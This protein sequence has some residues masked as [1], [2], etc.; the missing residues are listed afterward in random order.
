MADLKIDQHLIEWME[1]S[2]CNWDSLLLGNGFSMNIWERFGYQDL[3][4]LA[5]SPL[6]DKPLEP[7]SI[8]LFDHLSSSNFE[9]VLRIIYHSRLVDQQLGDPQKVSITELYR[10]TKNALASAV[11]FAHIPHNQF[12]AAPIRKQLQEFSHIFT[13]NYDL[14][15]YWSI[16][17]SDTWRFRDFFWNHEGLFNPADVEALADTSKI[18]YMHGAIHLVEQSDGSTMKQAANGLD[19]LT[20]LFDL[21]HPELFPLFISEGSWKEKLSRI[22]RNNYL[23]FCFEKFSSIDG[24]LVVIGHSLHKDYDQ[25]IIDAIQDSDIERIA[26][27]V[28]PHQAEAAIIE[29]KSRLIQSL[30]G[31]VLHFF[32]S[33]THPLGDPYL[34][35]GI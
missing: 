24:G 17:H 31:K 34:N 5:K 4:E 3:F 29:L 21:D 9:D 10:N 11:N 27:G 32:N 7:Q 20:E 26:L 16:M 33:E 25:H 1:V 6:V 15:P 22:K 13:T 2:E 18:Y 8:A 12:D 23:R 30:P 28:W 19:N 35:V 14:L